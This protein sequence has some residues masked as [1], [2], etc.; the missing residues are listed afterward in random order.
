[1]PEAEGKNK[2]KWHHYKGMTNEDDN[3]NKI[4]MLTPT[5][6]IST[7]EKHTAIMQRAKLCI[8]SHT[9]LNDIT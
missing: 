9:F 5:L 7:F 1:M 2:E 6:T 3:S 8:I 4:R